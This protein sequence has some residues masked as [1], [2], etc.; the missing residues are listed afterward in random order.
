MN[1]DA[2]MTSLVASHANERENY[3]LTHRIIKKE[4]NIIYFA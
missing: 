1:Q 3:P 4:N 2:H